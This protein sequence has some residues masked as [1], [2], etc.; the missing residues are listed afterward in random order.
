VS[1]PTTANVFLKDH[2]SEL[3]KYYDIDLL[4][5]FDKEHKVLYAYTSS[6]ATI[7][8]VDNLDKFSEGYRTEEE[9]GVE[10]WEQI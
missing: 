9:W 5:N 3:S 10:T 6:D 4:A 1:S 8:I 2:I 7:T